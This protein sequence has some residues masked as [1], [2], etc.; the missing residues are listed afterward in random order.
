M[1][2]YISLSKNCWLRKFYSCNLQKASRINNIDISRVKLSTDSDKLL[3]YFHRYFG[4][5]CYAI[6]KLMILSIKYFGFVEM[7]K[8]LFSINIYY[9]ISYTIKLNLMHKSSC[10]TL[11]YG[12][13]C[14][15]LE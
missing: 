4:N 1:I 9:R 15:N 8:H 2:C 13:N 10:P 5:E 11:E 6:R 7:L 14:G 3:K 12:K